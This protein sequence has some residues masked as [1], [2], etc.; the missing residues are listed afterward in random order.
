MM[1]STIR[2]PA[3]RLLS[4]ALVSCL[5]LAAAPNVMAQSANASLRGQVAGAQAG[6][7]V[8]ATNVATGTVRRGTV[9]A[10]GTYSLMGLDPGTYDVAANGQTQKVTVTVASTSTLNFSEAAAGGTSGG[11]AATNLDTVNV[12][13]PTLLQEVRTS[14]V[15]K[16]V[17]LQQIQTT[18]QVSR[19]FLEF[20]DAVPGLIFTRDAKGNTSLRGGATNSDGTNV[21]I[22]GVGQKSYVKGGG[23][24]GQSGSAGNPFPQLAIG[25]YKVISGNYKA[26]YGQV[27]SAAVTAATKS[28]TN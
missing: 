7:E 1:H 3:R 6:S 23:V 2:M 16:T 26:E 14:E 9:R 22:D 25:E 12:V 13:A 28:G 8:T 21:Y 10:D 18:P 11:S 5:M 24:A 17:S 27:S 20:A 15:G 19:N 4:T